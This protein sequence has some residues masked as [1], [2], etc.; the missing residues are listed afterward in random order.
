MGNAKGYIG[1][2]GRQ[3]A[4]LFPTALSDSRARW[5]ID[6]G[7]F[8]QKEINLPARSKQ[9]TVLA[10]RLFLSM[11][12]IELLDSQD[13]ANYK[14]KLESIYGECWIINYDEAQVA[15]GIALV[16]SS[17]AWV[18]LY[19]RTLEYAYV[20]WSKDGSDIEALL[21]SDPL[22]F[23]LFRLPAMPT[24]FLPL[25]ALTSKWYRWNSAGNLLLAFNALERRL[26]GSQNG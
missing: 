9:V 25:R 2:G 18:G 20:A 11:R 13:G 24:T 8:L 5:G 6:I 12:D 10:P 19:D 7:D 14:K 22:R 21:A 4:P 3:Y 23:L 17:V 16:N 1:L 15:S 26:T